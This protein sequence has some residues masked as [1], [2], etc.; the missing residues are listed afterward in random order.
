MLE[1]FRM[2]LAIAIHDTCLLSSASMAGANTRKTLFALAALIVLGWMVYQALEAVLI[3]ITASIL[4]TGLHQGA[5][6]LSRRLVGSRRVWLGAIVL[7]IVG[8]FV[9]VGFLAGPHLSSSFYDLQNTLVQS[10]KDIS[11]TE[12][13]VQVFGN[14]G[15]GRDL[16]STIASPLMSLGN[17]LGNI[18]TSLV[19]IF[20]GIVLIFALALFLVW[21]PDL[22]ERGFLSLFPSKLRPRFAEVL[23]EAAEALWFWLT[24]QAVAMLII[25]TLTGLGLWMIGMKFPLMLGLIAGLFAIIPYV[26]PFLSAVPGIIL[27]LSQS[28]KE[29]LLAG[30]VY[31]GVQFVEGNFVTPTVL[32]SKASLPPVL[33]LISTVALGLI[34]GPLGFIIA[35]PLTL[36]ALVVY[37]ELYAE[38][39]L[40]ETDG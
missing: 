23:S 18:V 9:G 27:A 17:E 14:P 15:D 21:S 30:G 35:T 26:G 10:W 36:V 2:V 12:M 11:S 38:M 19:S 5:I 32:R 6:R 39:I 33:T 1:R 16:L 13:M 40:G 8:A 24:G 31:L 37:R 28:P 29:A 34:F 4:A 7:T 25:G 20:T 22:Y 3:L